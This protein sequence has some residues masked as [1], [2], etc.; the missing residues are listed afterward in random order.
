M[1]TNS[2]RQGLTARRILGT[3]KIEHPAMSLQP[4]DIYNIKDRLHRE[5]L[6]G[7]TPVQSLVTILPDDDK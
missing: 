3:L 5:F 1:N 6:D 2:N 4:R 7:R